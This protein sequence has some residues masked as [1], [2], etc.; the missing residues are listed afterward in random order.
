[1][2]RAVLFNNLYHDIIPNTIA[3]RKARNNGKARLLKIEGNGAI[4]NQLVY[5]GNFD[6][7]S[8][9]S[10]GSNNTA[11]TISNGVAHTSVIDASASG[12][13]YIYQTSRKFRVVKDRYYLVRAKVKTDGTNVWIRLTDTPYALLLDARK[14]LTANV[15]TDVE[16]V[17]KATAS[18][19]G[20]TGSF[21]LV[22]DGSSSTFLDAKECQCVDLTQE[23]GTGNEPTDVN[24]KRI[25]RIL[26]KYRPHNTG[27][28]NSTIIESV[29][30]KGFNC[31]DE[32]WE[33]GSYGGSGEKVPYNSVRCKNLIPVIGGEQYYIKAP[34]DV[35]FWGYDENGNY[36]GRVPSSG[37]YHNRTITIPTNIKYITFRVI[38]D[39]GTTYNH[40]ICINRSG[41]RNGEYVPH[42]WQDFYQKV[43][44]IEN[45]AYNWLDTGFSPDQNT[46]VEFKASFS[47][48]QTDNSS[49]II[50]A[51]VGNANRNRFFPLA[52]STNVNGRV[53]LGEAEQQFNFSSDLVCEGYLDAQTQ[54]AKIN[55]NVF[56]MLLAGFTKEENNNIYFFNTSGYGGQNFYAKGKIYYTKFYDNGTLVRDFIPVYRKQDGT[57]GLYDLVEGKFY[58]NQGSGTF[59]KGADVPNDN[60][61]KLPAPLQLDGAI[62]SR[63]S[64]EITKNG[65]VFTRRVWK[66]D[67][68]ELDYTYNAVTR[69]FSA[70]FSGAVYGV[71]GVVPN[72]IALYY[73]TVERKSTAGET[74]T[75]DMSI[76]SYINASGVILKN[77]AYTDA[78]AFKTAMAGVPFYYELATPQ[79]ITI[80]KK[81]LGCVRLK[82]LVWQKEET[83]GRFYAS[84]NTLKNQGTRTLGLY[85][86]KYM[87]KMNGEDFRTDWDM[88]IYNASQSVYVHDKRFT[89]VADFVNSLDGSDV[90]YFETENEVDDFV[91]EE[92]YQR[93]GEINGYKPTLPS[94]YERVEYL[95]SSGTQWI[96]TQFK[97]TGNTKAVIKV[98]ANSLPNSDNA[99]FEERTT[100]N[101][102]RFGYF[103]TYGGQNAFNTYDYGTSY[104]IAQQ[105][106]TTDIFTIEVSNNLVINGTQVASHSVASFTSQY[107]L[108]LFAGNNQGTANWFGSY[109]VYSFKL[110]E[111]NLLVRDFI[112]AVRKSD[113][114]AGLYDM[115]TR[116]FFTNQGSGTFAVGGYVERP[117]ETCEV[118]PNV[119]VSLQCK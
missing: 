37:G 119:E 116:Q 34:Y 59:L 65:Y 69:Y 1:M 82:D 9:W 57:I 12:N 45:D 80:P 54:K 100:D 27:T 102:T 36:V 32:E 106:N 77:T 56:D 84:I 81:H 2:F 23:F 17:A 51:R 46:R 91:N 83:Y 68:G 15:W 114:V 113:N 98:K 58:V 39:Y 42:R 18:S 90:L 43:E 103:L 11:I 16:I 110:Y 101:S 4:E 47:S 35:Y 62:N 89:A 75:N 52:Y 28:Y 5:N 88:T 93:G 41:E 99:L 85:T 38:D 33:K 49:P 31:W 92:L 64:F 19:T 79:V 96:D 73:T 20:E 61:I 48:T 70:Q 111:N 87:C 67:L 44:Y 3:D 55:N 24:D 26:E 117:H 94:E 7:N 118:L 107:N 109:K 21:F 22:F 13:K 63:N 40:D 25:K 66:Q 60:V 115:V 71:A 86:P 104:Q 53:T 108:F 112:P 72:M 6:D 78:T 14:Q 30:T 29:E 8:G 50:G 74:L 76:C 105:L 97:P 10:H 95:E